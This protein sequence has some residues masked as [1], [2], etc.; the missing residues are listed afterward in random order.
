M[1]TADPTSS[2]SKLGSRLRWGLVAV[3]IVILAWVSG[4]QPESSGN[5]DPTEQP[6]GCTVTVVADTLNVR[7]GPGTQYP[8]VDQ[9]SGGT[10]VNALPATSDGFQQLAADR[11][12]ASEYVRRSA[13]CS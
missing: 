11:W 2:S 3:V 7:S 4:H 1:T 13:G 5:D 12:V 10:V 8:V 6:S 9:L